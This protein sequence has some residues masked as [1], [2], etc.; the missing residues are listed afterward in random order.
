MEKYITTEA[1]RTRRKNISPQRHGGQREKT[2]HHRGTEGTEKRV[3]FPDRET[4]V[5]SPGPTGQATIREM[6]HAFPAKEKRSS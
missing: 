6:I 2:Y 3:Y 5:R 1:R 4:P